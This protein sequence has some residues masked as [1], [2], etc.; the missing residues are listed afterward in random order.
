M[1]VALLLLAIIVSFIVVRIGA[2]AL[3]L[4]GLSWERAKFQALSAFTNAGFT[5]QES[6]EI[7]RHPLRRRIV[8]YLIVLGNA[9]LV[10]TIG[11]FAGP[12]SSHNPHASSQTLHSLP[13]GLPFFSGWRD[14]PP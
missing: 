4:T 13:E 8:S 5:T 9:G 7:V 12:S 10:A 11:S 14:A 2:T 1:T 3:E 6:E